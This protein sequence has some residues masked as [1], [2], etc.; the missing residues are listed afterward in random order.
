MLVHRGD[1][2]GI[3]R[4]P[5]ANPVPLDE[6]FPF[7][8]QRNIRQHNPEPF[9]LLDLSGGLLNTQAQSILIERPRGRRPQLN[10]ILRRNVQDFVQARKM[11]SAF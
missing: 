10:K 8:K 1:E 2:T 4:I 11:S 3:V 9:Y 7:L 6:P 5:A